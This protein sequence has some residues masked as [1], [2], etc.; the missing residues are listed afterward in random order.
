[1]KESYLSLDWINNLST[2]SLDIHNIHHLKNVY[3]HDFTSVAFHSNCHIILSCIS[4]K[5]L[6]VSNFQYFDILLR[7]GSS[8]CLLRVGHDTI[9]HTRLKFKFKYTNWKS[10]KKYITHIKYNRWCV[11]WCSLQVHQKIF[12]KFWHLLT[13]FYEYKF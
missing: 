13:L 12:L 8:S 6:F 7:T 9:L 10:F 5:L 3:F 1:M 4:E 11:L 2:W